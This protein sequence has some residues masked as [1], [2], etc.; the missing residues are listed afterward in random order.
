MLVVQYDI[1]EVY[2]TPYGAV[3]DVWLAVSNSGDSGEGHPHVHGPY[4]HGDELEE[5]RETTY[6]GRWTIKGPGTLPIVMHGGKP[7]HVH[8]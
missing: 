2:E 3:S 4:D 1:L 7:V 6:S 8:V 5:A